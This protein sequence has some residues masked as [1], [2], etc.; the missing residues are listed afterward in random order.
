MEKEN[1]EKRAREEL[2]TTQGEKKTILR[3]KHDSVVSFYIIKLIL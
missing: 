3:K 1:T 2:I